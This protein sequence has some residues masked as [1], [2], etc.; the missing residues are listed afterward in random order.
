MT[1]IIISLLYL[2][3]YIE[4]YYYK[5][6]IDKPSYIINGKYIHTK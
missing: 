6:V 5:H 1:Q 3:I 4:T 2:I